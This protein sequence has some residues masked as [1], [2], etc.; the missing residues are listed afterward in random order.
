M[1]GV[2]AG[3]LAILA[4]LMAAPA[5]RALPPV[6][7]V[8][9]AKARVVLFGSVHLLPQGLDWMPPEL[10]AALAKSDEIWFE[11]PIDGNTDAA[12]V[13]LSKSHGFLPK[14]DSLFNHLTTA[15]AER[16]R[17]ACQVLGLPPEALAPTR[18]WLADVTHSLVQDVRSG[19]R[20]SQGVEQVIEAAAPSSVPRKAFETPAQQIQVLAGARLSDQ[21]I[22]L[23][24]TASEIVDDPHFFP[25]LVGEWSSGDL[26]GV[27]R[28]ALGPLSKG[29]PAL[30]AR[31]ITARNQRWAGILS[32]RLK[33]KGT[34]VVVVGAGHLIGPK[35]V[36][37]LLRA[38]GF[39]VSGPA[40]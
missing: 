8:T 40:S 22:S 5:A 35:G 28:D 17:A 10:T 7:T 32:Q 34:V 21:I 39:K 20:A 1:R 6:W 19:G 30:Y 25:R 29:S 13:A 4:L 11:L 16:V 38:R 3:L 18:P 33:H 26:A 31:L 2:R 24:E 12:A 23:E 9:S 37:A 15:Q 36:P 14:G 27:A